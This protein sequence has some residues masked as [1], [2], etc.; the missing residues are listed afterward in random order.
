MVAAQGDRARQLGEILARRC[1]LVTPVCRAGK[2]LASCR[3]RGSGCPVHGYRDDRF[4]S[5]MAYRRQ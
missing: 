5:Q 2:P 4:L 1:Y 3:S